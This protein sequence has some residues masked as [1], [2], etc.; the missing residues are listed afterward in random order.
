MSFRL[1][2]NYDIS[3]IIVNTGIIGI[4]NTRR[5]FNLNLFIYSIPLF[6][7]SVNLDFLA[8]NKLEISSLFLH[9]CIQIDNSFLLSFQGP[10]KIS[11]W[12][13]TVQDPN[14]SNILKT[15][16]KRDHVVKHVNG[17][18]G[19]PVATNMNVLMAV[20]ISW[21]QIIHTPVTTL[22]R[23]YIFVFLWENGFTRVP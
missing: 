23:S 6:S 5:Y 11:L 12:N 16:G 20:Y 10:R 3:G 15:C 1:N 9:I 8:K 2:W 17:S 22:A 4:R 21:W 14:A 18:I 7:F 19:V 13:R